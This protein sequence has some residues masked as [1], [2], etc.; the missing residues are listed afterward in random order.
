M[1]ARDFINNK[2]VALACIVFLLLILSACSGGGD[3]GNP[4]LP[5][6]PGDTCGPT[7]YLVNG[8]C[9]TFAEQIDARATTAFVENGQPVSLE[10]VLFKPLQ[11][12]R[13]PIIVFNHGSTGNGSDPS[14]FGLTFT[15]KTITRYF[16]EKGWMVA[17]PQRRGRGKSDGLYDEG[18][19]LDRSSYSCDEALALGGADHALDD[20]DAITDWIRNR[21]DVDTTRML[22]GG[23]SRGGILSVAFVARRPDVYL[24]A[25]NFVGGWLAEGCGDHRSVN[26]A[27][28]VA[29]AAF[30]GSS[31]WLYGV[32]DSFYKLA[33]SRGNF[34]AY[35]TA[36]GLGQFHELTRAPGLNGHFVINDLPLWEPEMD[37]YLNQLLP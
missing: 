34:D 30:P 1:T 33:Y 36:G 32:N 18:F 4:K 6:P 31:L 26:R 3:S 20:L 13:F 19:K 29:G 2:L 17:F 28:F 12:G 11:Q 21:G 25:I 35:R 8:A 15:S 7:S 22:I 9:Q 14:L 27:L 37:S 10:V 16:V 23:T 24:G 5:E